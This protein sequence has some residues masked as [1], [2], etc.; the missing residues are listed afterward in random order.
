MRHAD[1]A[2][3]RTV[4]REWMSLSKDKRASREQAL[5]FA[6]KAQERHTLKEPGSATGRLM[7]WLLPRVGRA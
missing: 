5:A 3:R 4:I 1:H 6:E 7:G 2:I